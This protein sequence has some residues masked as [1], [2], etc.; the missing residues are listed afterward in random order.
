MRWHRAGFRSYWRWKT[1]RRPGRPAVSDEIR[2]L[3][4]EMSIANPLWGAPRIH[5]ELLKI[6]IA[7]QRS[8]IHGAE[9]G[10]SIAG[11]EDVCS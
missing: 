10:T 6:G 3:I 9:E 5:G 2:Q 7:D 11:L 1:R 8:Q 4:R